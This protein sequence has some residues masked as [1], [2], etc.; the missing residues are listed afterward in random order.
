MF[1]TNYT[2]RSFTIYIIYFTIIIFIPMYFSRFLYKFFSCTFKFA[3]T[4][5]TSTP[6]KMFVNRLFKLSMFRTNYSNFGFR[7]YNINFRIIVDIFMYFS[8]F[9]YK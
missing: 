9:F 3:T 6:S 1:R 2:N 4:F 5:R 7:I 8:C